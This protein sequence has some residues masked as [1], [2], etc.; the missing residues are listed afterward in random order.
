MDNQ[1]NLI[2]AIA[3]SLAVLFAWQIFVAGPQLDQAQQQQAA[4]QAEQAANPAGAG[5]SSS[6]SPTA[7]A[8]GPGQTAPNGSTAAILTTLTRDAALAQSPRVKI[9]TP[10][11]TGSINLTGGRID[12]LHLSEYHETTD[13]GS[14]TVVLLSPNGAPDAYFADFSWSAPAGTPVSG[15]LPTSDTT[16]TAPA[17]ATLTQAAPLKLT[18]D[19][20]AGLLFTRTIAVDDK[21]MFTV[22][23][24]VMNSG[25]A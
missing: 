14:P 20:G 12:D 18:Y 19:N 16:W 17:G 15:P 10:R 21:Y 4:Q 7:S 3:L 11:L 25:I 6:A 24:E 8:S 23:D 5:A 13:Q 1:R 22:T 2:L 9:A